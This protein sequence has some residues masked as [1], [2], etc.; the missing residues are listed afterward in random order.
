[1]R[2]RYAAYSVGAV[3]HIMGTTHPTSPHFDLDAKRWDEQLR[4]FCQAMDF[5][6]LTIHSSEQTESVGQVYFTAGLLAGEDD[7]SF[8]E[9]SVFYKVNGVWLYHSAIDLEATSEQA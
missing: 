4:T 3:A 5:A 7:Q 2:S 9:R 1:M 8:S 6:H